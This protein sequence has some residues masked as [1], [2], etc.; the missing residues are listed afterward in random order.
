MPTE[1][2]DS[3]YLTGEG[4]KVK[5]NRVIFESLM[6]KC[7]VFIDLLL[8]KDGINCKNRHFLLQSSLPTD[9]IKEDSFEWYGESIQKVYRQIVVSKPLIETNLGYSSLDSV[10][11]PYVHLGDTE[12]NHQFYEICQSFIKPNEIPHKASLIQIQNQ[13]G[14]YDEINSWNTKPL[15][16]LKDLLT[17]IQSAGS[18]DDLVLNDIEEEEG[19]ADWLS[20]L[21]QFIVLQKRIE[22]LDEFEVVPNQNRKFKK[23]EDL[24]SEDEKEIIPDQFIDVLKDLG[25]DWR[26]DLLHRGIK[27]EIGNHDKLTLLNIN[28]AIDEI[29]NEEKLENNNRI[30]VFIRR[31]DALTHVINILKID[32]P[33]S[34]KEAFR[35]KI[36]FFAKDLFGLTDELIPVE[37]SS[38]YKYA[39]ALRIAVSL[40]NEEIS[41]KKTVNILADSL[42][43]T[44]EETITWLS[45]YLSLIGDDSSDYKRFLKEGNI[46]PNRKNKL[47][48]YEDLYNYGTEDQPLNNKLIDILN[49]FES[50]KDFW[51][52][53]I[54]D[55]I[56][57]KLPKTIKFDEIGNLVS[58]HINSI[59]GKESYEENRNALLDLIDWCSVEK[60]L[61]ERYLQGFKE[62]SNRIFFI[63]TIENGSFGGNLI[64][65]LKNKDNLEMLALINES[66]ITKE[67]LNVFIMLFPDGIPS[68]IMEYAKEDARR[69]KEFNN[70]LE[71]GSKVER[72][73]I[74]ALTQFEVTNEIIHAGG[75][76]Y[77]IRIYNPETKKSFYIEVKSCHY[78]NIDP[79]NLAVS[80]VKRAVKELD[81]ETFSIVIVERS[82]NNEMDT[83]YIKS[84]TKYLKNPG[85]YLQD[86]SNN[87]DLIESKANT[88]NE[89]DL[90]MDYA[91]FKGSIEYNWIKDNTKNSGFAALIEDIKRILNDLNIVK[92]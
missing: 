23:L 14:K 65:I 27:F 19:K 17:D 79:I 58:E 3:I 42:N 15:Y 54:A 5:H 60:T 74:E 76:A 22:L 89:I 78:K 1:R 71:V 29:L 84:N 81:K 38:K 36:F 24:S 63:L 10:Y 57:L 73:F 53:L 28:E 11:V 35:H 7:E 50:N 30:K 4:K 18:L 12:V 59:K 20:K 52:D 67:E 21:F 13:I 69:K 56:D 82:H 6:T 83:D 37:N 68:N 46:V 41:N 90:K 92:N 25:K 62:I 47:C 49:K 40:I 88:L 26:D 87:Y 80:Q 51:E 32:S 55:K 70:L 39:A 66:G 31:K 77:D 44:I 85:Q 72:L 61:A 45:D 33:D 2:R 16:E 8:G 91:E 34:T 48:A 86:I 75:G 64:E 9:H 43:K